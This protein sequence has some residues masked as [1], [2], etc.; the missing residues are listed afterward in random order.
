MLSEPALGRVRK[1]RPHSQPTRYPPISKIASVARQIL[2]SGVRFPVVAIILADVLPVA[3]VIAVQSIH[4]KGVCPYPTHLLIDV[5]AK[6]GHVKNATAIIQVRVY[7]VF[8]EA[9]EQGLVRFVF[10]SCS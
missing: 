7:Q 1:T 2:S 6:L 10:G 3:E 9:F 8:S 5:L 4:H